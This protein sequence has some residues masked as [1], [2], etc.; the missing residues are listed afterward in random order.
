[1]TLGWGSFK[2]SPETRV[3]AEQ[4]FVR[5]A[6][7]PCGGIQDDV[8]LGEA[9]YWVVT[10]QGNRWF[11]TVPADFENGLDAAFG[12]GMI[13]VPDNN[14]VAEKLAELDV[15]EDDGTSN[16]PLVIVGVGLA[17]VFLGVGATLALTL[18]P[19]QRS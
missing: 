2:P 17:T 11:T 18:L 4:P 7:D 3:S 5:G 14:K 19:N 13:V 8:V 15:P 6:E 1:M 12:R 16:T 10:D 9:R